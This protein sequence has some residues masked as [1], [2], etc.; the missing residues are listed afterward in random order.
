M[1]CVDL[2]MSV[3]LY[4]RELVPQF[5]SIDLKFCTYLFLPKKLQLVGNADIGPL[6][7]QVVAWQTFLF[8]QIYLRNLA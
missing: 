3:C 2:V 6:Y 8:E 7:H 5:L 4:R 1:S